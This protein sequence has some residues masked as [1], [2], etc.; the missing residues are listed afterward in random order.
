MRFNPLHMNKI[1][2]S[3]ARLP[4]C[5]RLNEEALSLP[6]H[7]GLKDGDVAKIVDMVKAW[8]G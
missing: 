4:V 5:E 3:S 2:G 1:Y 7:P 6:L 8:K